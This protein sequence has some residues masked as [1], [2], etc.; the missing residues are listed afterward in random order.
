MLIYISLSILSIYTFGSHLDADVINNVSN[1]RNHR[2]ES[3]TLRVAFALVIVA[4]I[5]YVFFPCKEAAL[6]LIDEW[7][8]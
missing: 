3:L 5:L 4:H 1:E 7:D 8:R 6:T 2:W